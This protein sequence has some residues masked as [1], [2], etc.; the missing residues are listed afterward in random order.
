[1][2]RRAARQRWS[3]RFPTDGR[4]PRSHPAPAS[5]YL[6]L[7]RAVDVPGLPGL[8]ARLSARYSDGLHAEEPAARHR[9][10]D[11]AIPSTD[12]GADVRVVPVRP[13]ARRL[14][15]AAAARSRL[16]ARVR[17]RRRG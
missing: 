1:M 14:G 11:L 12:G 17:A 6:P 15:P 5:G 8:A 16:P 3:K 4:D 2:R 13:D 7:L 10:A 9:L